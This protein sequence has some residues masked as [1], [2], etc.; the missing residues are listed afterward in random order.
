MRSLQLALIIFLVVIIPVSAQLTTTVTISGKVFDKST[1]QPLQYATVS[2]TDK[3]SGKVITGTIA[4]VKGVFK[5]VDIPPGKYKIDF[6]FIGYQKTTIDSLSVTSKKK[7]VS[8][9]TISL[10]S[11]VHHLEGVTVTAD[12]PVVENK[13][14]K[15]VYNASNDVTS[16]GGL[17]IDVLKKVPQV[18]VDVDGNVEL[19]G[20]ANIRF[21][22]NGK[23]SSVFGSSISDAL[24]SIPASQIKS[25][26]AI[27]IPGAKYDSQGTGGIINII[28]QDS[29]M[30]G[31]N[32]NINLSA[33]TRLENGSGN[34]NFRHKSF[35]INAFFNGRGILRSTVPGSQQRTSTDTA[36]QQIT[37][38]IRN[39]MSESERNGLRSGLGF[40]WDIT[41]NDNIT[42][43]V[44]YNQ[45]RNLNSGLTMQEQLTSDYSGN[46]NSD[47]LSNSNSN[48]HSRFSSLDWS[49]DYKRKFKKEGQELDL[50]YNTSY[51]R[52]NTDYTQTQTYAGK[53]IPY[54]GSS[55]L[56][57][58]KN[59]ETNIS[60]DYSHP[61]SNEF[62]I[63][64]G[65]KTSIQN[66]NSIADVSVFDPLENQYT[67]DPHQS[68]ALKYKMNVYAGYLSTTF[69]IFGF[70]N[71]KSGVRYES[72]SVKID[73]PN[74]SIPAYGTVVPSVIFSHDFSKNQSLK[75]AY[76]KRIERPEYRDLNPFIDQSDPYNFST[77]NPLLKP[78]LGN[79]FELG[80]NMSFKSGGNLYVSLIEHINTQDVKSITTFYPSYMIGDSSYTNV[81]VT[82]RE[83][84]GEEYNS[85]ITASGSFPITKNFNLRGNL[86]IT[87]RYSVSHLGAGSQS[88][89]FRV[90]LNLNA[91][92]ELSKNLVLEAF[93]FYSSASKSIQGKV[94]QFFIYNFAFRK[95]F[96]NK[97][98][99]FGFTAT[100]FLSKYIRQLRTVTTD[101]STSS[102]LQKRPFRS[103]GI[104][105]T[106]KFGKLE[107]DKKKE[108]NGNPSFEDVGRGQ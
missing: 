7:V 14:D 60:L 91:S 42:G 89:G 28:L 59:K 21:L 98:A 87:N 31:V 108:D 101:N 94:P 16:Q 40:D 90:R 2:V 39:G 27:A 46:Q 19:Q 24:A 36:S 67:S 80:Y 52:P 81:S 35:G 84:V 29:K 56:N 23:P 105:F 6:N 83:N 61:V 97:N 93:G 63:E 69:K 73:F 103:F 43:S 78:E 3:A 53:T 95:L 77:G 76:S 10:L 45:F 86:M 107:F 57:P 22:I 65:L 85:G 4:D 96:W 12:K 44:G 5:L 26:E 11:S 34:F 17:A 66:I 68:Y 48:S 70:L 72:T 8:L 50:L 1:N 99:S 33:G 92:Y 32:G 25:V 79:N 51:G 64:A 58:G 9:G 13:I 54:S 104:S 18:T 49:L 55:S 15:I 106:Y 62:L 41:S 37:T 75:L 30:E 20:N 38:L 71:I 100:N 82:T 102:N 47:V 74:T 88:S